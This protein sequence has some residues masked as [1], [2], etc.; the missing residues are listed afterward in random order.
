[1]RPFA[2]ARP[3]GHPPLSLRPPFGGLFFIRS[4]LPQLGLARH[5]DDVALGIAAP[6]FAGS[7][8]SNRRPPMHRTV[9]IGRH[10]LGAP[11]LQEIWRRT[12]TAL[13]ASFGRSGKRQLS[14]GGH[15][16]V[17]GPQGICSVPVCF[18]ISAIVRLGAHRG[19]IN[20]ISVKGGRRRSGALSGGSVAWLCG[21]NG[22]SV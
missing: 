9:A 18:T 2:G 12:G 22:R 8:P 19:T 17:T 13:G 5:V 1:M 14:F 15:T 10:R 11:T 6:P 16:A 21:G 7:I 20:A 3:H 4:A